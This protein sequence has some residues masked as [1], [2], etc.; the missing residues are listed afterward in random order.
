M[1]LIV[2][3]PLLVYMPTCLMRMILYAI[4]TIATLGTVMTTL[5]ILSK[6]ITQSSH[7]FGACLT[8]NGRFNFKTIYV[9]LSLSNN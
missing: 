6:H 1:L 9:A 3:F 2:L 5:E 4:R 8:V 7:F